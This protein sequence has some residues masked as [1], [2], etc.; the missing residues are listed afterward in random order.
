[1]KFKN[2]VGKRMI[3]TYILIKMSLLT[4]GREY[5][6]VKKHVVVFIYNFCLTFQKKGKNFFTKS[7]DYL[8]I[9]VLGIHKILQ[10][11]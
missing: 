10:A 6:N 4:W 1:M 11:I 3:N 5:D 9:R 2:V 8:H 7:F